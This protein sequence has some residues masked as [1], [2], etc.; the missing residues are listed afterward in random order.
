[1]TATEWFSSRREKLIYYYSIFGVSSFVI[2]AFRNLTGGDTLLGI[3]E[4]AF[5][6]AGVLNILYLR[7]VRNTSF[8]ASCVVFLMTGA[9]L[10]F[11]WR[12]GVAQTGLYWVFTLPLLTYSLESLQFSRILVLVQLFLLST[13]VLLVSLGLLF[14]V[15]PVDH[16]VQF[17]ISFTVVSGMMHVY[18][19]VISTQEFQVYKQTT[20]LK[21]QVVNDAQVSKNLHGQSVEQIQQISK[22]EQTQKAVLNILEDL[23][24]EKQA[25]AVAFQDAKKFKLAVDS[26]SDHILI[27]DADGIIVYANPAAEKTTGYAIDEMIGKKAGSKELWGGLMD[28]V[29][30]KRMWD[31]IKQN[32]ETFTGEIRNKRKNGEEYTADVHIDPVLDDN[33]AVQFFVSVERDITKAK[34]VDRMK[35]EFISLASHQLRTPLSA[36]RWFVEMLQGGDVGRLTDDQ[37][38]IVE[39]IKASNTRMIE[40]VNALLNISRIESGRLLVQPTEGSMA[41]LARVALEELRPV[42][43]SKHLNIEEYISDDVPDIL[44]DERMI[45]QVFTNL[46]SNAIKYTPEGGTVKLC[47]YVRE[48][49]IVGQVE[50]T[51]YGVPERD[52]EKIFNRFFRSQN[53]RAHETEGTGL[54]LYLAKIIVESSGGKIWFESEENKGSLFAFS[55]PKSGMRANHGEVTFS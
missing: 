20:Q 31:T 55:I 41:K 21:E 18:T 29:Y 40:L 47:V 33:E 2:F 8:S 10:V 34:E 3:I 46:L 43:E 30:Y 49:E 6:F 22:L 45:R 1:M 16:L 25:T 53:V 7:F 52:K 50:D 54:G 13:Y 24:A 12:G 5:G 51:G 11:L 32:K 27:T 35:T 44:L 48:N 36:V 17:L 37:L 42:A 28:Q 19:T 4:L 15:Y 38:E 9:S 14:S 39:N 26:V 23:N